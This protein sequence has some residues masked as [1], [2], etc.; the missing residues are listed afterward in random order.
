MKIKI[1]GNKKITIR[2]IKRAD[3]KNARKFLLFINSLVA[4]EA[5]I[6]MNTKATLKDE[7]AYLDKV[8][9]GAKD[10]KSIHVIAEYDGKI[11]GNTSIELNPFRRNH[12]A[13]FAIAISDG[14]RRLGLGSF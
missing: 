8:I 12:S 14:Y 7:F 5:K 10:K 11:V 4:E 6:L 3:R 9:K 1:F 13:K 2:T